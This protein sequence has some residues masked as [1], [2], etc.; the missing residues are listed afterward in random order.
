MKENVAKSVDNVK[1]VGDAVVEGVT[2]LLEHRWQ[3][4]QLGSRVTG[5]VSTTPSPQFPPTPAHTRVCAGVHTF[6]L[7]RK[8]HRAHTHTKCTHTF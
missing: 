1:H 2:P 3:V 4:L 5:E 7:A 8:H 6:T